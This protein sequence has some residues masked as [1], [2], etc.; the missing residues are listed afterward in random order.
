L[1]DN[2]IRKE[3]VRER[4]EGRG[5]EEVRKRWRGSPRRITLQMISLQMKT[6]C[7]LYPIF[8]RRWTGRDK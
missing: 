4:K 5:E 2:E 3:V 1:E 8:E 7:T 6:T